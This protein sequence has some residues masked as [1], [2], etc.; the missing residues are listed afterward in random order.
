LELNIMKLQ[1]I[2]KR[3]LLKNQEKAE[4]I[5]GKEKIEA[6]CITFSPKKDT[7]AWGTKQCSCGARSGLV[8]HDG[9]YYAICSECDELVVKGVSQEAV[10]TK[11]DH[12]MATQCIL[13]N[14]CADI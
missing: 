9:L 11:W 2:Y 14:M 3:N 6:L 8:E 1:K 10:V 13:K 7:L 5:R 12:E 4:S